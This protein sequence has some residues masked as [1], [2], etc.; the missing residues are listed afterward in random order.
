[1]GTLVMIESLK[2]PCI[3]VNILNMAPLNIVASKR[4]VNS[5]LSSLNSPDCRLQNREYKMQFAHSSSF[6]PLMLRLEPL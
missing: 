4:N 5:S 1:V 6:L 2:K 3:A